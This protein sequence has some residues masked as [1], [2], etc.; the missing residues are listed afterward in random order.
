MNGSEQAQSIYARCWR[1]TAS[2]RA[3]RA[4]PELEDGRPY[5]VQREH[6]ATMCTIRM[7]PLSEL[8]CSD[9]Q[10]IMQHRVLRVV[11]ELHQ[12]PHE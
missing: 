4:E 5:N 1:S 8:R 3:H 11:R 7:T 6:A 9:L 2:L 12:P 10:E